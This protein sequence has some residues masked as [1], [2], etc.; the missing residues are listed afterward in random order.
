MKEEINVK[1]T[2]N[3]EISLKEII[4]KLKVWRAYILSKWIIIISFAIV[5]GILGYTYAVFKKAKYTAI[6]TFVLEESDSGGGGMGGSLSGL[7]SVVGISVGG[8]GGIFQGDNI[9]E[10]YKSRRMIEKAL[11]TSVDYHGKNILLIDRYIDFNGLRK[12]WVERPELSKIDF[13]DSSHFTRLQDSILGT[14]VFDINKRFLNVGKLDKKLSIIAVNV[15]SQDEFFAKAF[16]EQIVKNVNDFYIQTKTKNSLG[17]IDILQQKTDSVRRVMT[18][19]IYTAA[20]ITDATP[21]LNP[22]RQTQRTAPVQRSQ[23]SAEANRALL[24][25]L[26]KNLEMSKISLRKETP[27]IQVIDQPVYPLFIEKLGKIRGTVSGIFIMA[28]LT[29]ILIIIKKFFKEINS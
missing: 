15:D 26:V 5:G 17:N 4:Q 8:G 25:E 2:E 24:A 29:T 22:T 13:K 19:A 28:F 12:K 14:I 27:L 6:T 11:L 10:L 18:G 7:A 1:Q 9:L 20:A 23:F 3:E 16:N 21:N